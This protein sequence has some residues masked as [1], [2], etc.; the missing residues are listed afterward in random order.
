MIIPFWSTRRSSL[1]RAVFRDPIFLSRRSGLIGRFLGHICIAAFLCGIVGVR[2][3]SV[4][5]LDLKELCKRA[6]RIVRATVIDISPGT[7]EAG[8]GKIPTVTYR[9]RVK[10]SL[11]GS[12]L[13]VVD[14]T[15]VGN[16]KGDA[17]TGAVRRFP[18]FNEIPRLERGQEYLLFTTRASRIGLSTTVGLEQGC[19]KIFNRDKTEYAM[20]GV[21]NGG[22]GL[23][24]AGPVEYA[25]LVQRIREL[26]GN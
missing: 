20:N 25:A 1:L 24:T 7:V 15:M 4:L 2:G 3:S 18:L 14:L 22:L 26:R 23:K 6:E 10:E 16:I 11:G 21:H 9:L 19:F 17:V 12:P 13:G 5:Q 8:G